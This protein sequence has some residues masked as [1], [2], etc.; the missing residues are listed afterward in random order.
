MAEGPSILLAA[1]VA[2]MVLKG[3]G[4]RKQGDL[5]GGVAQEAASERRVDHWLYLLGF[6]YMHYKK[7]FSR[8]GPRLIEPV[9][10]WSNLS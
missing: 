2:S 3:S 7:G 8:H 5:L 9:I 10:L 1:P 4:F 6:F